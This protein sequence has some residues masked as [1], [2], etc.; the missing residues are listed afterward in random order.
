[1]ERLQ[2]ISQGHSFEE[3]YANIEKVLKY[4]IKWVQLRW[5]NATQGDLEFLAREIRQ[6]CH[7]Y[8]ATF[9]I[10][11]HCTLAEKVDADGVHLGLNDMDIATARR[12]LSPDKIIGGTA[13]T[14]AD[15]LQRMEEQCDYIGLGPLRFTSTKKKL[16]PVLGFEGYKKIISTLKKEGFQIPH[17]FA[18]G[19]IG[20]QDVQELISADVYGVAVSGILTETPTLVMHM[21][22]AFRQWNRENNG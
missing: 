13:N 12:I 6:L 9:I 8:E 4:G 3:Q 21:K 14:L 5:K 7:A 2:Y 15:V 19:G 17:I 16:S 22:Q 1:M 11:D 10:N 18:I 20:L